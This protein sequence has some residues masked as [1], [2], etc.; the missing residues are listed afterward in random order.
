[1]LFQSVGDA[2]AVENTLREVFSGS[3]NDIVVSVGR[4]STVL[5]RSM[6]NTH[7]DE[8]KELVMAVM[9]TAYE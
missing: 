7:Y 1:M 9:E 4:N 6:E 2:Q 8:L 3:A 5:L